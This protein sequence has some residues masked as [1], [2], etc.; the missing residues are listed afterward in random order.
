MTRSTKGL[1]SSWM[2][3]VLCSRYM[4][5]ALSFYSG[6]GF[7]PSWQRPYVTKIYSTYMYFKFFYIYDLIEGNKDPHYHLGGYHPMFSLKIVY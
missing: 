4:Y 2:L 1:K 3:M 6:Q 5:K 7:D